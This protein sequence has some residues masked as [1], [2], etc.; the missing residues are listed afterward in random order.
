LYDIEQVFTTTMKKILS[1]ALLAITLFSVVMHSSCG[2]DENVED[3]SK[4]ASPIVE[5]FFRLVRNKSFDSTKFLFTD[6]FLS[7]VN[8]DSFVVS[9]ERKNSKR[10][11]VKSYSLEENK[12]SV[13]MDAGVKRNEFIQTYKVVY[14]NNFLSKQEFV[15]LEGDL[16]SGQPKID[17]YRID[18][19]PSRN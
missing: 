15:F 18:F 19:Y 13:R 2:S 10:G 14:D 5:R 17:A 3:L 12:Y 11:N 1:T 6:R 8:A 16:K 9:L 4:N 7:D